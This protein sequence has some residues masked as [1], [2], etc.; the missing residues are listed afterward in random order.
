MAEH[1]DL[2]FTLPNLSPSIPT[3]FK[4]DGYAICSGNDP[5]LKALASNAGNTTSLKMLEEFRT[6][7]GEAYRPACFLVRSSIP[8]AARTADAIRAFRNI[9]AVAT[10]TPYYATRLAN[11][12]AAQWS[13]SWA[14]Q[15]QFGA[16]IAGSNGWVQTIGP[17]LGTD[18]QIPRQ[19]PAGA[20]GNPTNFSLIVDDSLL[21]RLFRAWHRCYLQ[22]R[23]R[24]KLLRLFRALEVAFHASLFPDDGLKSINDIG[25]RLALWVS[26]LEVLSHPG[27][28]V[29]KRTVQ[30]VLRDAPYG[31]KHLKSNR[32]VVYYGRGKSRQ[33]FA[34]TLP[35]ALYDDLYWAR[36]QFLH[37]NGVTVSTLRYRRSKRYAHLA[38]V[39]PVLFS[40]ALFSIL[41]TLGVR[42]GPMDPKTLTM[43]NIAEYMKSREGL[44]RIEKGIIA[45][46]KPIA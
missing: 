10:I 42:S 29:N 11:P 3:K 45:A 46:A 43:K 8:V 20:F 27:T 41:D 21:E 35:E 40:A 19:Q 13:V 6:G 1:W 24:R 37:G 2:L 15:F 38:H 30:K 16:F 4:S 39:A 26:A 18:N 33:R 5:M 17:V 12:G 28:S 9:C 22:G 36:N 44:E 34:A 23:D 7:N 25:S 32:F 14:D 31:S